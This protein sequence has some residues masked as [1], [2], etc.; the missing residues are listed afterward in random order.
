MT[1][2]KTAPKKAAANKKTMKTK[3]A[4]RPKGAKTKKAKIVDAVPSR[5]PKC[6]STEKEHL[7]KQELVNA[8]VTP[9]GEPF[10]TIVL[11]RTRCRSCGQM[12]MDR[13]HEFRGRK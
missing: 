10:D 13:S 5:C 3:K 12:R 11:R 8:G 4:G 7:N 9:A 2:K 1:S 6:G